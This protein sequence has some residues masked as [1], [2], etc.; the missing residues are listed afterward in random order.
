MK[1]ILLAEDNLPSRELVREI[2]ETLGYQVIEACDGGEA[3]DKVRANEPDLVL[4]DIQMPVMDGFAVLSQLRK[5]YRFAKLPV[6]A[7]T[8]YAME[9]DREKILEA[10]FDGYTTK[11]INAATL[12]TEI[13]RRLERN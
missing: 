11:P 12:S 9:G 8:A 3:L 1:R 10:G 13:K 2:L 5:E 7:L 6:I 4:M